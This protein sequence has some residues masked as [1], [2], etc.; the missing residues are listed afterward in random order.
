MPS[1]LGMVKYGYEADVEFK[2]FS[3]LRIIVVTVV[4][5][6]SIWFLRELNLSLVPLYFLILL[7]YFLTFVY[8]ISF[9]KRILLTPLLYAGLVLDIAC[10]TAIVHY[11]GGF[12][13]DFTFLYFYS[14]ITGSI[15]LFV[16]GSVITAS[17][18]TLFYG[19]LLF[20]EY[21]HILDPVFPIEHFPD[22]NAVFLKLYLHTT[23]FYIIAALSAYLS[24][25]LRLRGEALEEIKV[26]K[27]TILENI[28]SGVIALN[29]D[30]VI[31][32][33]NETASKI[34]GIPLKGG[35]LTGNIKDIGINDFKNQV[36][37]ILKEEQNHNLPPTSRSQE[38]QAR[39]V[40]EIEIKFPDGKNR[41]LTINSSILYSKSGKKRGAIIVFQDIT[42]TRELEKEMQRMDRL[43]IIGRFSA[44]LAH[45]IRNPVASIY[46]SAE[47]LKETSKQ[48]VLPSLPDKQEDKKL[49]SIIT[50]EAHHLNDI[51]THFISFAKLTPP[52][53]EKV[54]LKE[55]IN[56]VISLTK[57]E[58]PDSDVKITIRNERSIFLKVD[59][60]QIESA[61]KNIL[62]NAV[63]S[64][65]GKDGVKV[66]IETKTE[67]E[68]YSI[69]GEQKVVEH[70]N[71]VII[72]KDTGK[73]IQEQD[74]DKVFEPFYTTRKGGI[75]LGLSIVSRI[76]ENHHGHLELRSKP[77]QGTIFCISLPT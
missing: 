60:N 27:D 49:L 62:S 71:C 41:A 47:L 64:G 11:T 32:Y 29:N 75:G 7:T 35:Y 46:G 28:N 18:A 42:K 48:E 10:F 13:S 39:L 23:F 44:D 1:T 25:R 65:D 16:K 72:F 56:R 30:G 33:S 31:L 17:L 12:E 19:A 73:G 66:L 36:L 26:D 53:F 57:N 70:A 3:L 22:A 20:G 43:A 37:K 61:F 2:W 67:G 51:L 52:V 34:L 45:E 55:M 15:F 14:I 59:K 76:I 50:K 63:L 5:G 21:R 69:F 68:T 58:I 74:I 77:G 8:W 9:K 24:E 4:V 54:D 40:Q 38:I 6:I